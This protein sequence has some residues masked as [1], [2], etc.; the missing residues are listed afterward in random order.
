[1]VTMFERKSEVR[2][3][4]SGPSAASVAAAADALALNRRDGARRRHRLLSNL[5]RFRG[6]CRDQGLP[7][8]G[9]PFPLQAVATR[10][11][12]EVCARLR[13]SG[14][15]ALALRQRVGFI[16]TA[17]HDHDAIDDAVAALAQAW[18]ESR[19]TCPFGSES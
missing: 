13:R 2:W 19:S 18:T 3:H 17:R 14:I 16:I 12:A 6:A 7:L 11:P 9:P 4:A 8:V 15:E 1:M 10:G 5:R